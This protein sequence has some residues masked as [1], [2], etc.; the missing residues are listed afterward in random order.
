MKLR[1]TKA[2]IALAVV[3]VVAVLVACSSTDRRS[4]IGSK[5][6]AT[7]DSSSTR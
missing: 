5:V 2:W 6:D 7:I 3:G 1:M 4:W